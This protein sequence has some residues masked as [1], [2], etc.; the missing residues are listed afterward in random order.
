MKPTLTWHFLDEKEEECDSR[1]QGN[2]DI[3]RALEYSHPHGTVCRVEMSEGL[4]MGDGTIA[5]L[6]QIV[7]RLS[8]IST[9]SILLKFMRLCVLDIID[10]WDVPPIVAQFLKT[11]NEKHKEQAL[12]EAKAARSDWFTASRGGSVAAR[13]TDIALNSKGAL[14]HAMTVVFLTCQVGP[15]PWYIKRK[16]QSHRLASL[17]IAEAKR[18]GVYKQPDK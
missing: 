14:R 6:R 16:R 15:G 9:R 13:A 17:A 2:I 7:W 12:S 11:D 18:T 10:Y 3:L 5:G 1:V 8:E 4:N